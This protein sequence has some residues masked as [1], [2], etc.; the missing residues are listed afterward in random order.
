MDPLSAS[1]LGLPS[2]PL[3]TSDDL[4]ASDQEDFGDIFPAPAP[5]ETPFSRETPE[6]VALRETREMCERA[7]REE[8]QKETHDDNLIRFL[9]KEHR[10]DLVKFFSGF[11][12][13]KSGLID[14]RIY[15]C[16]L[17]GNS[18]DKTCNI[19]NVSGSFGAYSGNSL[20]SFEGIDGSGKSYQAQKLSDHI[21][22][23]GISHIST[24]QPGGTPLAGEIR[25]LLLSPVENQFPGDTELF[26]FCAA[27]AEH[28]KSVVLPALEKGM[29]II[30]DRF[31]DSFFAYE[32]AKGTDL[33]KARALFKMYYNNITPILTFYLDAPPE[34]CRQRIILSG[35]E[36]DRIEADMDFQRKVRDVYLQI[37]EDN[38]QRIVVLD[39]TLRPEAI[40]QKVICFWNAL[41]GEVKENVS[42]WGTNNPVGLGIQQAWNVLRLKEVAKRYL[43]P[44]AI[45]EAVG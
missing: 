30:C 31:S 45:C 9:P 6:E 44:D 16:C 34:V 17:F 11:F 15:H 14:P 5:T 37:A 1:L 12:G 26:L 41:Y 8:N 7:W 36:L 28:V 43:P 23:L 22:S 2:L 38:P 10:D 13:L 18:S 19:G 3:N 24:K 40:T 20:I 21:A 27:R 25:K 32:V 4:N 33:E 35:K 29:A 42:L 39:G